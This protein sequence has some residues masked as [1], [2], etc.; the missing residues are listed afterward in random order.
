MLLSHHHRRVG[1][2]R[3]REEVKELEIRKTMPKC[4]LGSWCE[5]RKAITSQ[6]LETPKLKIWK[7]L[8]SLQI[9][10]THATPVPQ[11]TLGHHLPH[12]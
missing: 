5:M 2:G 12:L 1:K 4:D 11:I 9:R 8:N 3:E 7:H 10:S 6:N